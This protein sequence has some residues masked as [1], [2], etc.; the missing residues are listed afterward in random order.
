MSLNSPSGKGNLALYKYS[1]NDLYELRKKILFHYKKF[2]HIIYYSL[3]KTS[4]FPLIYNEISACVLVLDGGI[5][6]VCKM[7]VSIYQISHQAK[8]DTRSI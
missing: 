7:A 2:L 4:I 1:N 6:G 3:Y 8:F 5:S